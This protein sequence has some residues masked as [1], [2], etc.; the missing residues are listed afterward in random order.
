VEAYPELTREDVVAALDDATQ[1]I[2]EEKVI[3][4]A[5]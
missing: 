2:D 5:S 4:R 3:L 1:V